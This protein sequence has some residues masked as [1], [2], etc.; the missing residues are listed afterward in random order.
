M[1][2]SM[3]DVT[4]R[5]VSVFRP[6]QCPLSFHINIVL[7]KIVSSDAKL[8]RYGIEVSYDEKDSNEWTGILRIA[9]EIN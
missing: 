6:F 5:F 8:P 9:G 4:A 2:Q 7:L 1:Y 3:Y